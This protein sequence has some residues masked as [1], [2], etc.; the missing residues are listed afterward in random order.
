MRRLERCRQAA[1]RVIDCRSSHECCPPRIGEPGLIALLA[2]QALGAAEMN[3][4]SLTLE[5]LFHRALSLPAGSAREA[6]LGEVAEND[7]PLHGEL[8]S[9]LEAHETAGVSLSTVV[10]SAVIPTSC[11]GGESRQ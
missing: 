9:L 11:K 4:P 8:V 2:L 3:R 7:P 1:G 10:D 5:S 6:L